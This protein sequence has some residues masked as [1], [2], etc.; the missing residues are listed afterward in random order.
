[1]NRLCPACGSEN[2]PSAA[3]CTAC[4]QGL[5]GEPTLKLRRDELL[6]ELKR[7]GMRG[8]AADREASLLVT[9]GPNAGATYSLADDVTVL[10]R[11]PD[12]DVFL[13]DPTVS[14]R[15]AEIR[16]AEDKLVIKDLGS[17][18]G[19]YVHK[20]RVEST[21]LADRDEIQLGRYKLQVRIPSVSTDPRERGSESLG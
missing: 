17:V 5:T 18:N 14:R 11:D 20:I 10:G 7:R 21:E 8:G 9:R 2:T 19:T 12:S 3:F 6:E 15:H 16:R 13:I 1:M 4:G